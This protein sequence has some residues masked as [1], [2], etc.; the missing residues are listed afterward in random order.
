MN[1]YKVSFLGEKNIRNREKVEIEIKKLLYKVVEENDSVDFFVCRD[2]GFDILVSSKIREV[3]MERERNT[4]SHILVLP[5]NK[6]HEDK[7]DIVSG[8]DKAHIFGSAHR[9]IRIA[10]VR[11]RNRELIDLTDFTVFY[12]T[13][14]YGSIYSAYKYALKQG[15]RVVNIAGSMS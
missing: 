7:G 2:E 8:Y 6:K 13:H 4:F 12:F 3:K 10:T 9:A 5:D 11:E 15:K 1:N 14:K